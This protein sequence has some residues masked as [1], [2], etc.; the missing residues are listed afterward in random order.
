M[1]HKAIFLDRDG[2]IIDDVHL[3]TDQ[4]QVKFPP[5]SI[6]GFKLFSR[7]DYLLVVVSNQTVVAR[8]MA[9]EKKVR[10]INDYIG[11]VL[12]RETGCRLAGTYFCPHHPSADQSE[13]RQNC[14][15]RKPKPG[16]LLRA[17]ADLN[18]DLSM[19]YMVGDRI[20]DIVAGSKAGCKTIL[21]ETG[22]HTE[23]PI[24]S[25]AMDLSVQ[26][27]FICNDLFEAAEMIDSS[28]Q[29]SRRSL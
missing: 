3:L 27:D 2:V 13:Y 19:S 21:L 11:S 9:T 4:S 25:D 5:K 26:P 24:Q 23:K 8:G 29:T 7:M 16:M 22:K 10:E 17:A 12:S 18:I 20:S 15:C 28:Y 14:D 1:L 6:E